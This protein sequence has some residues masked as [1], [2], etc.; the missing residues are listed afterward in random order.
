MSKFFPSPLITHIKKVLSWVGYWV[1][2][3]RVG[4]MGEMPE[5]AV[6]DST[7]QWNCAEIGGAGWIF[8]SKTQIYKYYNNI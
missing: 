2:S 6:W 3:Q 4:V 5:F 8:I 7:G 1:Y